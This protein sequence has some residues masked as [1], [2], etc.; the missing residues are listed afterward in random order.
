VEVRYVGWCKLGGRELG[1]WI[2]VSAG[3]YCERL[4][5]DLFGKSS[6]TLKPSL[7]IHSPGLGV[8]M[9]LRFG[10]LASTVGWNILGMQPVGVIFYKDKCSMLWYYYLYMNVFLLCI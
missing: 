9:L 2:V 4:S 1:T 5:V 8:T 3:K 6:N 7:W 10:I